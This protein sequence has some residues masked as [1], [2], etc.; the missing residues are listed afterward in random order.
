MNPTPLS[1]PAAPRLKFAFEM[2]VTVVPALEV[3][4]VPAGRRRIIPILGGTFEGP[5]IRG[6]VLPGGADW[7]IIRDDGVGDLDTRYTLE[8]DRSEIIYVQNRGLRHASPENVERLLAGLP[9]DPAEVYF[10]T[11]PVFETAAPAL[12]WMT[13]SV[14]VGDAERKPSDVIVRF[15]MVE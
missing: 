14:F 10:R 7:Q 6:R 5:E 2:H 12:Q 3:G 1:L 13:R 9:V 11:T 15:W 8:T 4:N